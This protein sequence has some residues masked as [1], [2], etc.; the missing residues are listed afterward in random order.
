MG[1]VSCGP[2]LVKMSLCT[3]WPR[4]QR[5]TQLRKSAMLRWRWVLPFPPLLPPLPALWLGNEVT[6]GTFRVL[7]VALP[8]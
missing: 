7:E 2:K 5:I 1:S 8:S 6:L 3:G 4:K